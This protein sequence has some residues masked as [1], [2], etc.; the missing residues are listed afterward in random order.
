MDK[1]RI[2]L[3]EDDPSIT[4]IIKFNL[5]KKK[6]SFKCTDN[7]EKAL[8]IIELFNPHLILLDW[9]LPNMSGLSLSKTLKKKKETMQIPIIML[10][11]KNQEEDKIIG[12]G[13]GIDDYVTKPFSPSELKAR[14]QAVLR[15]SNPSLFLKKI[16][17]KDITMNLI[18]LEV[19]RANNILKLSPKEFKLLLYFIEHPKQVYTRE[20]LLDQIWGRDNFVEIRTVDVH[21]RRLRKIINING[22]EDRIKTIRSAGY[23]LD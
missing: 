11:A 22:L 20:Q 5:V 6:Y 1:V 7:A 23:S 16:Q 21:I 14:I 2:L 9:M 15:R 12:F 3:I 19:I 8:D 13:S 10:T 4:E 18:T 17:Y